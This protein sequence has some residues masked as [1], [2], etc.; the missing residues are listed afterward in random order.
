MADRLLE[1]A[2]RARVGGPVAGVDEVGRGPLAGP[3]VAAAVI[4]P[5]DRIIGGLADSKA[6]SAR[7]RQEIAAVLH[8]DAL[9]SIAEATVEEIDRLNILHAAMLA[10]ARA[11]DALSTPAAAVLI[12]GNRMPPGLAMP[13]EAVVKGDAKVAAIAAASIVAKVHRDALMSDLAETY[14]GYGFE[15][16]AGYPTRQHRQALAALG[17][18]P[19]HRRSFQPVRDLI[20]QEDTINH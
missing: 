9:V 20:I 4:L 6:L 7:R 18:C 13:G 3:V 16:H 1:Q 11:I 8:Q 12:D 10:M 19:A 5:Y 14:P 2:W 15:R 17:P